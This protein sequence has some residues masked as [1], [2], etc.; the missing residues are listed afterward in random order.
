MCV[1]RQAS[2][3]LKL[4]PMAAKVSCQA[5]ALSASATIHTKPPSLEAMKLALTQVCCNLF[6]HSNEPGLAASGSTQPLQRPCDG[7]GWR[8]C[9]HTRTHSLLCLPASQAF[10]WVNDWQ[11]H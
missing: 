1:L 5:P 4:R 10:S 6:I 9:R 2:G 11:R 7:M 3:A 8:S